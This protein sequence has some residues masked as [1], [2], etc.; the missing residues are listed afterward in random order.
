MIIRFFTLVFICLLFSGCIPT[1][2]FALNDMS[3]EIVELP[4]KIDKLQIS[5]SRENLQ[6]MNWDVPLIAVKTREW[7][8]NPELSEQNKEDIEANIRRSEKID[9]IPVN[10][11]FR[12]IEGVC[13]LYVDWKSVKEF[14]KFK[15][16]LFIE[17]PSRNYTYKS[18]ATMYFENP[19][20]NGTEKGA[21]R[22][23]NQAVKNVTN[24][25]LKQIK[26]E[27]KL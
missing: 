19:T 12:I 27:I 24:M 1:R 14:A 9:G 3:K 18:Y 15:G 25:V 6:P 8:G 5:D 20:I 26:D 2:Q 10:M 13:E 22:L 16:E 17:I 21:M 11:E 23:Y 4:F 7:K